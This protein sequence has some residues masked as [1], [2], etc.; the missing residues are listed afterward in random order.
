M[1]FY[2][3][4]VEQ[5]SRW[6]DRVATEIVDARESFRARRH[7]QLVEQQ[8]GT[9]V[10]QGTPQ[11]GDFDWSGT[12]LKITDG[13]VEA[14]LSAKL[15]QILKGTE[16][17]LVLQPSRFMVRILELP[18]RASDFLEGIVRA[19]IDRLTPWSAA[20]AAFGWHPAAE[21]GTDRMVVTIAATG[22]TLIAPFMKAA[23]GLGA[24]LIVVSAALQDPLP[25]AAVIKICEQKVAQQAGLR[26][27][28]RVLVGLLAAAFVLSALSVTA[29]VTIGD[30][31][32][33]RRDDLASR[34]SERRA[35]IQP[36]HDRA[37][38]AVLELQR[39]KHAIPSSAIIIEAL[40]RVLPDHTY[41]TELRILGDKLQIIGVTRD[42]PSLIR[43][44]DQTPHFS[45]ATFFAPTTRSAAESRE[46]FSIEAHI[47][48]VFT[49]GL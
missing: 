12:S 15:T 19:Q 38:D 5:L 46:H 34:I 44:I 20:N 40:S 42:A 24:D 48:P 13:C 14:E 47:E 28:R 32:V 1:N 7:F 2:Q 17:E 39:R 45:K 22:R 16:V 33:A 8:D 10:M 21:A 35:A 18:R 25:D 29:S 26:R 36:G 23:A 37:S 3:A 9:F 31:L 41:L 49:P 30:E 11:R 6:I 27:T 4:G 43:L